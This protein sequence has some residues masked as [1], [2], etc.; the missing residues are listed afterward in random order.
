VGSNPTL[1]AN[2]LGDRRPR[3]P[4]CRFRRQLRAIRGI[5]SDPLL[6]IPVVGTLAGRRLWPNMLAV[7]SGMYWLRF[8][9]WVFW[10]TLSTKTRAMIY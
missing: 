7:A 2:D 3:L 9:S 8:R 10:S 5:G 4:I 1:S 6:E